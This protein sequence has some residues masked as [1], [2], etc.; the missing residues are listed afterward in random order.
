[1]S[2]HSVSRSVGSAAEGDRVN[3]TA[4][5]ALAVSL[6]AVLLSATIWG[7]FVGAPLGLVAA[8]LALLALRGARARGERSRVAVAALVL[9]CLAV[10]ALPFFLVACIGGLECV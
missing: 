5:I 2:S 6:I 10:L 1:M 4:P 9:A 7:S 8:V 3:R